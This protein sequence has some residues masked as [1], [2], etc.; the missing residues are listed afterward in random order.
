[1]KFGRLVNPDGSPV[2][3]ASL[4]GKGAWG[5]TDANGNFQIEA[6]DDA[7]L[8]VTTKDGR[9]YAIS[10]PKVADGGTIARIGPVV[11]CTVEQVQLGALDLTPAAHGRESQ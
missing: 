8:T 6:P 1:M 3:H 9:S 7:E 5:E 10:L 4:V 11:C 2:G